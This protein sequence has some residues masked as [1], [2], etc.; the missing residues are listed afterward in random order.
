MTGFSFYLSQHVMALFE[1]SYSYFS[2]DWEVKNQDTDEVVKMIG[3]NMGGTSLT[4][5]IA[6]R[7]DLR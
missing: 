3:L 4:L 7:L 5:G 6:Y 2:S 1:Y